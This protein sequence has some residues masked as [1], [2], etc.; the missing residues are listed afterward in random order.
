MSGDMWCDFCGDK[1]KSAFVKVNGRNYEVCG[2]CE[3]LTIQDKN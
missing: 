2:H 1:P 3:S